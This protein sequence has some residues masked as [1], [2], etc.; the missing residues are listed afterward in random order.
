M[1]APATPRLNLRQQKFVDAYVLCGNVSESARRAGYS[2]KTAAEIGYELLRKPQIAAA[3]ATRQATYAAELSITKE[4]VIGGV[5]RAI[6]LAREQGNP[7][8]MIQ[9]CVAL[10]KLCG[11]FAP[12]RG[13]VAVS[14]DYSAMRA[15]LVAMSD[16]ELLTLARGAPSAGGA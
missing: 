7:A 1:P 10:A 6:G 12:E 13:Q 3:V 5:A 2:E 11:F 9:G 8:A 16:D 14:G 4:D 15:K